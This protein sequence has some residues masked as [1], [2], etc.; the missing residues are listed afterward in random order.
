MVVM[1]VNAYSLNNLQPQPWFQHYRG[2]SLVLAIFCMWFLYSFLFEIRNGNWLNHPLSIGQF[3]D[4]GSNSSS[5]DMHADDTDGKSVTCYVRY[6][7]Y[8]TCATCILIT[9]VIM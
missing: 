4:F 2:I 9:I 3:K 7:L 5:I 1:K 8:W 6:Q